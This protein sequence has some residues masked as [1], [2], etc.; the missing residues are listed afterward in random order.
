MTASAHSRKIA[1]SPC[2]ERTLFLWSAV[3]RRRVSG[4]ACVLALLYAGVCCADDPVAPR[5]IQAS[6]HASGLKS[7]TYD[8]GHD[9]DSSVYAFA[10]LVSCLKA[11]SAND[12]GGAVSA[13]T[14]TV[15][16]DP[17]NL[18]GFKLRGMAYFGQGQL[19]QALADFDQA[20]ALD[21]NDPE[22]RAARG[23]VF[24]ERGETARALDAYT[25]AIALRPSDS[26]WWNARCWTRAI[27]RIELKLALTDCDKAVALNP[28]SALAYDSRGLV[29]L[30]LGR[31]RAAIGDYT[32]ALTT[33]SFGSSYFGRGVAKLR[34]GDISGYGDIAR[35]R[36]LDRNVDKTFHGYGITVPLHREPA[37]SASVA[38]NRT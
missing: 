5:K 12:F 24:R 30:Q 7:R 33:A 21:P 20:V 15:L 37:R 4:M 3:S 22:S 23:A 9:S 25:Q 38:P 6:I 18:A 10:F 2:E 27:G 17:Q 35:A 1:P 28:K 11:L 19:D 26:R 36:A 34:L 13:C 31:Y 16:I 14:E 8:L 29:N 32:S